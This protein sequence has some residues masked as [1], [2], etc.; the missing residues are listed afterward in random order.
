M[1]NALETVTASSPVFR[2]A[3]TPDPWAWPAWN[4]A[5]LDGTFGN[6]WD[7]CAGE[8]RVLY[9]SST[10]Y[11]A[12]LETLARFRPDL[13]IVAGLGEIE[14]EADALAAGVVPPEWFEHRLIGVAD[15]A[16]TFADIGAAH[17]LGLVR[18][19]L[20]ARAIHYGLMDV[21]AGAVRLTAPRGFTQEV[22]RLVY[23]SRSKEGR[24]IAGIRYRS[25]FDDG[26]Y[27]WAVFESL[28]E[29]LEPIRALGVEPLLPDTPEVTRAL[30]ALGLRVQ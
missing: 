7:D 16:G 10:R 11:G 1:S 3:R 19:K 26:T 15:L 13:A 22:S 25:R 29:D 20:A 9:A 30:T 21:D 8:Y 6:R 27:N 5:G 4:Q 23:E 28:P 2:I 18:S 12:L 14:G 24:P 17:S